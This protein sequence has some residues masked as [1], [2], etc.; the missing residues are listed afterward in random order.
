[1]WAI[2]VPTSRRERM[3]GLR[4]HP[5]ARRRAEACS[6][7]KCH[8]VHTFG[9]TFPIAVVS[10]DHELQVRA[11]RV[12]APKRLLAPRW[13]TRHV[14]ECAADARIEI[15]DR[16][17]QVERLERGLSVAEGKPPATLRPSRR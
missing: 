2:D 3:R 12:M 6:S 10:L 1:M 7:C 14:M 8:S 11:V 5:S 13:K 15:G 17:M 9:M 16:F 4:G